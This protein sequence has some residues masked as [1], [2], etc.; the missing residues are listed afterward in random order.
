MLVK[1]KELMKELTS[2]EIEAPRSVH[3]M[4]AM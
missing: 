2:V 4:V 1:M 3:L